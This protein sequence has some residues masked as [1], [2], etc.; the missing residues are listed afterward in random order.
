MVRIYEDWYVT[1]ETSPLNYIVRRGSGEIKTV[2]KRTGLVDKPEAFCAD[3]SSAIKYVR[4]QI[5]AERL[6]G[7]CIPLGDALETVRKLNA[8]FEEIIRRKT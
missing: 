1:V 7:P 3:L 2:G 4:E 6:K 5:I 8:E